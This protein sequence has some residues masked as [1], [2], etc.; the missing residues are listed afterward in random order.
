MLLFFNQ[1]KTYLIL[2]IVSCT[3][4]LLG[5]YMPL[6]NGVMFSV[7]MCMSLS[8]YAFVLLY[9]T[10]FSLIRICLRTWM[11]LI[12]FEVLLYVDDN[13]PIIQSMMMKLFSCP[14]NDGNLFAMLFF[15]MTVYYSTPILI[16]WVGKCLYE[17]VILPA[18]RSVKSRRVFIRT[19]RENKRTHCEEFL[20]HIW[21]NCTRIWH[22]YELIRLL[23]IGFILFRLTC[24]FIA[25]VT[26]LRK[27][28]VPLFQ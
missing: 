2:I 13:T 3:L 20:L 25:L 14:H 18:F 9:K 8:I 24:I 17:I 19:E 12:I 23:I 15:P 4:Y 7:C 26:P 6:T 22:K 27:F 1:I 5:A 21:E 10:G 16:W 28:M 11:F